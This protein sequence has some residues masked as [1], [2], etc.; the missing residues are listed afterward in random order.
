MPKSQ[1]DEMTIGMH[2]SETGSDKKQLPPSELPKCYFI[3]ENIKHHLGEVRHSSMQRPS[4]SPS[5]TI[6]K[7]SKGQQRERQRLRG[8]ERRCERCSEHTCEWLCVECCTWRRG[9]GLTGGGRE[10]PRAPGKPCGDR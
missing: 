7:R 2:P 9:R 3:T 10:D 8:R 1:Q 5:R 6:D 4:S